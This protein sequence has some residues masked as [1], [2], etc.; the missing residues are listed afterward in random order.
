VKINERFL[1]DFYI[2]L[3]EPY[4][5]DYLAK[6]KRIINEIK[7]NFKDISDEDFDAKMEKF[8][9]VQRQIADKQIMQMN[10]FCDFEGYIYFNEL[11]FF[12]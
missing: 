2:D 8:R 9:V 7:E 3:Q 10:I 1:T 6:K 12:I 11:M 4:G 5:F